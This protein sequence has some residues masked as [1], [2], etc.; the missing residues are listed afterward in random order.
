MT[1]YRLILII[2]QYKF[3][4]SFQ[5]SSYTRICHFFSEQ[6]L[7]Q[8]GTVLVCSVNGEHV[9]VSYHQEGNFKNLAPIKLFM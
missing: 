8:Q 5:S 4:L 3:R 6:V 9:L 7:S 2:D 1:Y